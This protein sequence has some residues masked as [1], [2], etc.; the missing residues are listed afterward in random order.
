M[1]LLEVNRDWKNKVNN[2]NKDIEDLQKKLFFKGYKVTEVPSEDPNECTIK[3]HVGSVE[4]GEK[5]PLPK[6]AKV[7]YS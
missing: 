6:G 2:G 7:I 5:L 3:V 4:G 1:C